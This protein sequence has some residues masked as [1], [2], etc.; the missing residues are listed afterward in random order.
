MRVPM[1]AGACVCGVTLT[2][3]RVCVCVC[4][5]V[6]S[7]GGGGSVKLFNCV[8]RTGVYGILCV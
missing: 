8:V 5:C 6:F 3:L 4:V 1:C 7:G 2:G